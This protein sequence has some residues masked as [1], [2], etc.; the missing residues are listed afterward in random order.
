VWPLFICGGEDW[1]G[2]RGAFSFSVSSG[3]RRVLAD[4]RQNILRA[5]KIAAGKRCEQLRNLKSRCSK[6]NG[7][8]ERTLIAAQS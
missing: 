4:C 2:F 3:I 6:L 5:K 7:L 8:I 1:N